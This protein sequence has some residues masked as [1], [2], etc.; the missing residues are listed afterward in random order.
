MK[1]KPRNPDYSPKV[2]AVPQIAVKETIT[3]SAT[4][5]ATEGSFQ[6]F[7]RLTLRVEGK[8]AS[9]CSVY[10]KVEP[11]SEV[12]AN[13][14]SFVPGSVLSPEKNLKKA[15]R[16]FA[17]LNRTNIDAPSVLTE[18][19]LTA[20]SCTSTEYES[21]LFNRSPENLEILVRERTKLLL[22]DTKEMMRTCETSFI[23][24]LLFLAIRRIDELSESV[25]SLK[26]PVE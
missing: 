3:E 17:L 4:R 22:P 25:D 26:A 6:V 7:R 11:T 19:L 24:D 1:Q 8:A 23:R 13:E 10:L 15:S 20:F 5:E 2:E 18:K 21:S 9:S 16:C 12:A 14:T